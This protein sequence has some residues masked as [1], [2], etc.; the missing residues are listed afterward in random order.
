MAKRTPKG[1]SIED[2]LRRWGDP[3]LLARLDQLRTDADQVTADAKEHLES[4]CRDI[5]EALGQGLV[6]RLESGEL[7]ARGLVR[8]GPVTQGKIDID[9]ERWAELDIDYDLDEIV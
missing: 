2:A 7:R 4:Q 6:P 9:P 1:L 5:V 3:A 8:G